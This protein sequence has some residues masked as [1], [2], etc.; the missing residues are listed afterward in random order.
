LIENENLVS[1]ILHDRRK[2][3]AVLKEARDL[4]G[5]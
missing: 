5:G 4:C 3:D 1:V 2:T